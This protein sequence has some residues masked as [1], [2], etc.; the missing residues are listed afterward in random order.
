[1]AVKI[2]IMIV[3]DIA[4]TRDNLRQ[5]LELE[6]DIEVCGEATNGQEALIQAKQLKPDLVLMDISMPVMDGILATE[7]MTVEVPQTGIIILTCQEEGENI[8]K[9]MA[10][11][12]RE[13]LTKPPSREELIQSVHRV[14]ELEKRRRL[15]QGIIKSSEV[16]KPKDPGKIISVFSPKGG[17]G[18]S[19]IAVNLAVA[20]AQLSKKKTAIIDLNLQFGD[21]AMLLDLLPQ[22]TISDLVGEPDYL[23]PATL[24][25]YLL[26]HN[27]GIK[28]LP[29]PLR[30]EYAEVVH[31]KQI[32]EILEM[33]KESYDYII[34]DTNRSLDD[35]TL[36]A[37]DTSDFILMIAALDVLTVKSIKLVLETMTSLHYE[38]DKTK[39]ILNYASAAIGISSKDLATSI[40]LPV[41][42]FIPCDGKVVIGAC[43]RGIPF[44]INSPKAP[45][46]KAIFKLGRELLEIC[47]SKP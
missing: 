27:S 46:S 17:V 20:I 9:A 41:T 28:V 19:T 18:K 35:I 5:L 45:V 39:L 29:A 3:D 43:N 42:H 47:Y 22:R 14:Y 12:A 13:F 7:I 10:A 32:E 4:R 24:E 34:V 6:D 15:N 21:V 30:P 26:D 11:G 8:H 25:S 36:S 31:N 33:M 1:M 38:F 2:R 37:L 40:N 23:D 44:V 16:E